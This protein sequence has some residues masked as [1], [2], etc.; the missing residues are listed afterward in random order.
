MRPHGFTLIELVVTMAI[1]AILAAMAIPSYSDYVTRS[2]LNE[3]FAT[4]GTFRLRMEQAYQDSGNYGVGACATV[5]ASTANFDYA[6]AL[7]N[8]G[9]G[10]TV[11]A[12]GKGKTAAYR[13]TL[14]DQGVRR[15]LSI[16]RGS[17]ADCWLI[18]PG[19]CG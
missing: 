15:T 6:C 9:Q 5:A 12:T 16:P 3:A 14:D 19:Q 10:F 2:A 17:A 13:Y 18:K 11:T 8:A 7:T 4:M 1:V